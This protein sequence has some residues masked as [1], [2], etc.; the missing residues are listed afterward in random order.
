MAGDL[1]QALRE[2]GRRSC[3]RVRAVSEGRG[4]AQQA[5]GRTGRS[6]ELALGC[7]RRAVRGEERERG[8]G[9]ALLGQARERGS[10]V[11]LGWTDRGSRLGWGW[12]VELGWVDFGFL[13]F[14]FLCFSK[15]NT[16]PTI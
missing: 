15:S 4:D 10:W 12:F 6:G 11:E 13:L 2:Q 7:E 5:R 14:Y 16:T 1:G 8:A 9:W 3:Q